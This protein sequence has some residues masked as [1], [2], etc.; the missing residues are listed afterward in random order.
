MDTASKRV[1][2]A[3]RGCAV[4]HS[5]VIFVSHA[6]PDLLRAVGVAHNV[7]RAVGVAHS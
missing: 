6:Y 7:L 5:H 4:I 3:Q 2:H 1:A